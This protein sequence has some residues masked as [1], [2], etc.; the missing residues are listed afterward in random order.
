MVDVTN[1]KLKNYHLIILNHI[2]K[3]LDWFKHLIKIIISLKI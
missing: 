2:Q 3:S 1:N